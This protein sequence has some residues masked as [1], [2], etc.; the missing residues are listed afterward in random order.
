MHIDDYY[1][2]NSTSAARDISYVVN[3]GSQDLVTV[4]TAYN[5][6]SY[7][8]G[9]FKRKFSTGDVNRDTDVQ[10]SY[11]NTYCFIYGDAQAFSTFVQN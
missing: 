6:A 4:L 10:S 8:V 1:A 9:S 7:F 3:Q 5:P 11:E 2:V